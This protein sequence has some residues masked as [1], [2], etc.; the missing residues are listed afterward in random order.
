MPPRQIVVLG[1]LSSFNFIQ[2]LLVLMLLTSVE[3]ASRMP[4][5]MFKIK[6]ITGD[7]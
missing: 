2:S 1:I 7:Y 6:Y 4:P 3:R 5:I